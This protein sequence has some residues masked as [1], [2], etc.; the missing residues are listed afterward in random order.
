MKFV[1]TFAFFAL[2][3]QTLAVQAPVEHHVEIVRQDADITPEN[4]KY[5]FETSDGTQ[6]DEEGQLKN[7]GTDDEAIV[8]KGSY[9]YV[10]DDGV[11]YEV[12][13]TAD[14]N[15]FQP[16]GEHLPQA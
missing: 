1:I 6:H 4:Y 12:S 13:Y 2:F 8:V 3:S 15:G 7:V 11:T 16:V 14:E 10:G 9:K 5:G